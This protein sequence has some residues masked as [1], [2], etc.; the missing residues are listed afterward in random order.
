MEVPNKETA[1]MS[2]KLSNL[3]KNKSFG[4]HTNP[5]GTWGTDGHEG[6]I[7]KDFLHGVAEVIKVVIQSKK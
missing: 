1:F 5:D 4:L 3:A 6:Q 7:L 2:K